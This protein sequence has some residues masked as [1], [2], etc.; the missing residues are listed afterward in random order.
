M[1]RRM[2]DVAIVRLQERRA[3]G[4]RAFR[5]N[6]SR[7]VVAKRGQRALSGDDAMAARARLRWGEC[8]SSH[9]RGTTMRG[10][11]QR[12]QPETRS[13]CY[14]GE[15]REEESSEEEKE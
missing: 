3:H 9:G 7:F 6:V 12:A 5:P 2:L 8:R 14:R 15:K 4:V 1:R 13:V 11:I 10:E